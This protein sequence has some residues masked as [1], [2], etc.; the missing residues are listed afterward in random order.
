[1]IKRYF[2]PRP[3]HPF[4]WWGF[5]LAIAVA[6]STTTNPLFLL[7]TI[8]VVTL[9]TLARRGDNPW[10]KG[11]KL[12]LLLGLFVVAF[13]VAFRVVFGGGDGPTVLF[14]LPEIP[15]PDFVR[16]I[17]LLGPVSLESLLYG[18][19][20][21]LRLATMIIC[22]GAANS[23]A[24]P[25]RLLAA[26]PS[27]LYEL[28]TILIV[29]F[30]VFPQL[31]ESFLRVMRVRKLRRRQSTMA[32]GG[33]RKTRRERLGVVETIIIPVLSDALERSIA[34]AASMEVRGYGRSGVATGRERLTSTAAGLGGVMLL[35][36][37]SY[38]LLARPGI[39][40]SVLGVNLLEAA[41][42][43][44]GVA[45]VVAA[46]RM[47]GRHVRRTRYRRDR[48][49]VA[50]TLTVAC[51]LVMALIVHYLRVIGDPTAL[52]P[53]IT[54]LVWPTLTF[55]LL[56]ALVVAALPAF[57]TPPPSLTAGRPTMEGVS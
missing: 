40:P 10:A 16:G 39:G 19:Y 42:L 23:L 55:P 18:L 30:S 47:A 3:L 31:G 24:N 27:A 11:Y 15:L 44:G 1:M 33:G 22:V 5:A 46:L 41:L 34:L 28:G 17:R 32:D 29:S 20:D 26:L 38:F 45:A 35:A 56:A 2:L 43:V 50:E 51:G 14:T 49:G 37:W 12:Y 21:G 36:V 9:V 48:W 8:A 6:A 53:S 13:R 4:A 57:I 54:P 25:K 52:N 7:G